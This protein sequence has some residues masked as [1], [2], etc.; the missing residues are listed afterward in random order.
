MDE[1]NEM[2]D[3]LILSGAVEVAGVDSSTGEFLYQFTNKLKDI[4]PQMYNEHI[5]HVNKEI[6][7]L[8]EMGFLNVNMTEDNPIV[9]ITAKALDESEVSKL[10]KEDRWGLEEIKRLLKSQEL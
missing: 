2:L 10:A 3:K 8:W 4:S 7:K 9:T 1:T 6:M 5:N